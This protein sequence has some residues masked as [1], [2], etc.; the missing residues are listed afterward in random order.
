MPIAVERC[1]RL[2]WYRPITRGG[3]QI[4]IDRT[5]L[6]VVDR[7]APAPDLSGQR[8]SEHHGSALRARLWNKPGRRNACSYG[9]TDRD[10]ATAALHVLQRRLSRDVHATDID[11]EHTIHLL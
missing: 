10:D 1:G 7:D 8:L 5:R 3:I 9:R 2:L 11:V 4:R 6:H